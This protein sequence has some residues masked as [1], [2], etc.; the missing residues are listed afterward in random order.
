MSL[1]YLSETQ[2]F[3]AHS[4][5]KFIGAWLGCQLLRGFSLHLL[6]AGLKGAQRNVASNQ[7]DP[8]LG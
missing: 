2:R 7:W 4:S 8:I 5:E 1:A 3:G 6:E